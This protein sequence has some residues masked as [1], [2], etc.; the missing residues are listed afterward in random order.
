MNRNELYRD[1][2][3]R[4]LELFQQRDIISMD[5]LCAYLHMDRRTILKDKKCPAKKIAGKY[6]VPL[7]NL[8]RYLTQ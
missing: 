6:V 4:L 7:V 5:E 8:A 2:L 3:E 1:H